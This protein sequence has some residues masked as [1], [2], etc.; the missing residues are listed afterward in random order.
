MAPER[1]EVLVGID[2]D[3]VLAGT[4][5]IFE[6][7]GQ[8]TTF[9]YDRAYLTN[10]RSYALDPALPLGAGVFQPPAG[11]TLFNAFTDCAPDRWGQNLMRRSEQ[12]RAR[13]AHTTPR[14][15]GPVDFLLGTRDQLR[16]GSTRLRD[17][18]TNSYLAEDAVGVPELV[19]L[20]RLLTASDRVGSA[21]HTDRAIRDL[22]AAGSSLGGARPKAAIRKPDGTLAIAKFPRAEADEWDVAMWEMVENELARRAGVDVARAKLVRV[23]N[24]NVL[25]VDRFDRAGSRRAGFASALTM[26]EASDGDQRSYLEIAE[27]LE[28][29]S[30]AP[31]LELEQLFRRVVFSVLTAN[32][33]DHLRNHGFLRE[34]KAWVLSPAYDLNPNPYSAGVQSTSLGI[35]DATA[36]VELA[37]SVA[38]YYRLAFDRAKEIVAEIE[39]STAQWRTVAASLRASS[40]EIELMAQAY[41]GEPTIEARRFI[42]TRQS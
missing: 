42:S 32:T 29:I 21:Q 13:A 8:S 10:A 1:V 35:D 4:L 12:E 5:R 7:R 2:G 16:Q 6:R 36:S 39:S 28:T 27:V 11:R 31:G 25:L 26:L 34:G 14:S 9:E 30:D 15:L 20:G 22:I 18:N 23:A 38:G 40:S 24:R 41:E 37:C 17:P 3:D 33:D 19:Q